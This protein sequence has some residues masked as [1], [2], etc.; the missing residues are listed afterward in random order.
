[1]HVNLLPKKIAALLPCLLLAVA[2][3]AQTVTKSFRKVPLK[4]VLEEVERQTGYSILFE[5]DKVDVSKPITASFREAT[6]QA[7]LN[8]VLDKSLRYSINGGGKLVTISRQTDAPE[9]APAKAQTLSGTVISSADNQPI[10]GAS[11]YVEGTNIGMHSSSNS[12][13]YPTRRT[14]SRM[15]WSWV[16]A[17]RRRSRW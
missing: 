11:I 16:S 7:V 17:C 5:N 6:L 10:V 2:I 4:T 3:N 1:M 15:S 13:R 14:N 8:Q 12:S 9:P